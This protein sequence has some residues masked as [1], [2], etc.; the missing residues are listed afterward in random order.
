MNSEGIVEMTTKGWPVPPSGAV[1]DEASD[2]ALALGIRDIPWTSENLALITI[3][4]RFARGL[5][6]NYM[7]RVAKEQGNLGQQGET[8]VTNDSSRRISESGKSEAPAQS[9]RLVQARDNVVQED[10]YYGPGSSDQTIGSAEPATK[11]SQKYDG[12]E[13][14]GIVPVGDKVIRDISTDGDET[15]EQ[16]TFVDALGRTTQHPHS[17]LTLQVGPLFYS[18]FVCRSNV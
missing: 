7:A 15:T 3:F 1:Q 12:E 14:G 2:P 4:D 10:E 13:S 5:K 8:G 9:A 17:T 16:I 6:E 18:I 11:T